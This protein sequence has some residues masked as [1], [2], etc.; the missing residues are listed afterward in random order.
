LPGLQGGSRYG[1]LH[2]LWYHVG[3]L[4]LSTRYHLLHDDEGKE[5][6]QLSGSV[7]AYN[8]ACATLHEMTARMEDHEIHCFRGD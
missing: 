4:L 2:L 6:Q 1:G 3:H 5:M 8:W 7:V